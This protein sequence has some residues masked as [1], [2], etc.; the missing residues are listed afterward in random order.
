MQ[1]GSRKEEQIKGLCWKT[2]KAPHPAQALLPCCGPAVRSSAPEAK[3]LY[4]QIDDAK[5]GVSIDDRALSAAGLDD[6]DDDDD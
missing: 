4:T 5:F 1:P 6:D 2:L 3:S